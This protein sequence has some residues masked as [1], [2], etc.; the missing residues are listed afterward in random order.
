VLVVC[1]FKDHVACSM[2]ILI[3]MVPMNYAGLTVA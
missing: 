2:A 1:P 3:G